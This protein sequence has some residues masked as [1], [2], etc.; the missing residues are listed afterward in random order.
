MAPSVLP[1]LGQ[2]ARLENAD[3]RQVAGGPPLPTHRT[4]SL[5]NSTQAW[6]RA[7]EWR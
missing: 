2:K 1:Q 6:V 4:L 7:P 5:G 3:E